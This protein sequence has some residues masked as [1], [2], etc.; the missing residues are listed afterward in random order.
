[1]F[2]KSLN[3]HEYDTT[4]PREPKTSGNYI[5]KHRKEKGLLIRE[6]AKKWVSMNSLLSIGK[7]EGCPIRD[8]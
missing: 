6:F 1:V 3:P 4:Y 7:E 5:R 8:I 2:S